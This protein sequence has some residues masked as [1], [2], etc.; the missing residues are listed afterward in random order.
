MNSSE[1]AFVRGF[2]AAAAMI[3]R[4]PTNSEDLLRSIGATEK[5]LRD[6]E[7]DDFDLAELLPL[8]PQASTKP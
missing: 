4:R 8:L 3:V 5:L 1:K 2:A 6:V 7:V